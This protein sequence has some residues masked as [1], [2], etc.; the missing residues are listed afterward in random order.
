MPTQ[1]RTDNRLY[2]ILFNRKI[3]NCKIKPIESV[4]FLIFFWW[5]NISQNILRYYCF[6][7]TV[8]TDN[9]LDGYVIIG[10]ASVFL[11]SLLITVLP[12]ISVFFF[13]SVVLLWNRVKKARR[14][15][16]FSCSKLAIET[17]K[18]GVKYVQSY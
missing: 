13:Y 10:F 12:Y 15:L 18:Q 1:I 6:S 3:Q 4:L 11:T 8:L 7:W 5:W 14:K 2:L 16:A 17:L 9:Y